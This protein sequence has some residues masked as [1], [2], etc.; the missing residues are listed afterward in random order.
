MSYRV[1]RRRRPHQAYLSD[2]L[3]VKHGAT[4]LEGHRAILRDVREERDQ[5][6]VH[7]N[8][9]ILSEALDEARDESLGVDHIGLETRV[10]GREEREDKHREERADVGSRQRIARGVSEP[11]AVQTRDDL[12]P[13]AK[14]SPSCGSAYLGLPLHRAKHP[15]RESS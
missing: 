12:R 1:S 9:G 10:A 5:D 13:S 8:L 2:A 3:L 15:S 4:R 6:V 14:R 11:G 7:H